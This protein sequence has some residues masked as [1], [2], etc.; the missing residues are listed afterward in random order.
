MIPTCVA[1]TVPGAYARKSRMPPPLE[2]QFSRIERLPPYVFSITSELKMAARRRGEDIIDFGMGNPDGPTPQAHRRQAGRDRAASRHARLFGVEGHPAPA[3]ARSA[4][5]T[6]AAGASNSTPRP[7]RSSPSAR[8]KASRTWRSRTLG[9]GDTVLVPNPSYPIHIYGPVI[10]G[11]DIRQVQMTPGRR[12]LRRTRAHDQDELP[13]A[14]DARSSTFRPTRPRSAWSCRS[15]RR[16][17]R[18]RASTASTSCTTSPTPTSASTAGRRRRSCRCRARATSPS[19][20]S[21]CRRATTWR[22]G[23]SASWSAIAHLVNALARIKGYH[24]YGT[25]TPLQVAAIAALEGPQDCVAEIAAQ[26]PEA[27]RRSG[28]GPARGGLE[29]RQ[30]EGVDVR[31]GEDSRGVRKMGSLEFARSSSRGAKVLGLAGHRL[32]RV[33]A[34]HTCASR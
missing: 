11:A 13:E 4:T 21:R 8:R 31:L 14:E 22:A 5:G 7:R 1:R 20:S 19:S 34:T 24:D 10:A 29:S 28:E 30:P 6:N 25:F 32:R 9:R 18:S 15:S 2:T 33:S 17:S 27:A 26:V 3:R 12:L 23:G 16:S